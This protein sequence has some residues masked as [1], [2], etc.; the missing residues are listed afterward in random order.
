MARVLITD[1][2]ARTCLAATR[3]LGRRGHDVYVTAARLPALASSSRYCKQSAR[4]P[5]ARESP[6]AAADAMRELVR[7]WAIDIV[8]PVTELS[9]HLLLQQ[10]GDHLAPAILAAPD[11]HAFQLLSNK[12]EL[13]SRAACAGLRVP[14]S[15]VVHTAAD[16]TRAAETV[17]YPCVLKPHSSIV[18]ANGRAY[19]F[20]VRRVGAACD[21]KA[22]L[23]AAAF[24]VLVQE[25]VP[26]A[27]EGL[28]LMVDR[29]NLLAAF[30]HRRLRE[31]PPEGG[32]S[33][34]REAIALDP[35]LVSKSV[36]LLAQ[37][38]WRGAAMIEFRRTPRGEAV[39]ME[40]NG[41][42][43]GSLQLAV[44]AGVDFAGMLV[45]LFLGQRVEPVTS[46][47]VGVRTR[48]EW[49]E[50][51]HLLARLQGL[52][53]RKA[54]PPD[55]PSIPRLLWELLSGLARPD[56]HLEVFRWNDIRPF[57]RESV[58]WV[59]GRGS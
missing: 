31:K 7:R 45:A 54:A 34:Y 42:L 36:R 4:I 55:A 16:L 50:V 14:E 46:Y 56:D 2:E 13:M 9:S 25:Y 49:G 22:P 57:V 6:P 30:A 44:D 23:A 40:V 3:A 20:G 59:L 32:V 58:E 17:G 8:V 52:W 5:S 12:A 39:L 37:S 21:L 19:D 47:R 29:G 24:P 33:T 10:L 53:G 1:A 11:R 26:G 48:W 38:G 15:F 27:G 51:D 18:L 28:F 41:R 43:W 35:D